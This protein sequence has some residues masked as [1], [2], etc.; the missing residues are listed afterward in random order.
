MTHSLPQQTFWLRAVA[1][2]ARRDLAVVVTVFLL[3]G[4]L[5]GLAGSLMSTFIKDCVSVVGRRQRH[6]HPIEL[7]SHPLQSSPETPGEA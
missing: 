5:L 7:A 1:D 4:A 6:A 3:L 2:E